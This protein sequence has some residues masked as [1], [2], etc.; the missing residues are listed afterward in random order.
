MWQQAIGDP[1][2]G[3]LRIQLAELGSVGDVVVHVV[4]DAEHSRPRGLRLVADG[5]QGP[6]VPVEGP[7]GADGTVS[8]RLPAPAAAAVRELRIEVEGRDVRTPIPGDPNPAAVLPIAI[9][10][11]DGAGLPV[12]QEAAEGT[13]TGSC[14]ELVE[15]D[16]RPVRVQAIGTNPM[17]A[18]GLHLVA[19]DGPLELAA[20]EHVIRS[21]DGRTTGLDV[22]RLVL[23]SAADGGAAEVGPRGSPRA[24]AGTTV[25]DVADHRDAVDARLTSD[26]RPFW[27][28]LGESDNAGWD[29][30]VDGADVSRPQIVDGYANGWLVTPRRAGELAVHLDWHPQRQVSI[31]IV[32]SLLA[33]LACLVLLWR[34]RRASVPPPQDAPALAFRDEGA[35]IAWGP[36]LLTALGL[37]VLAVL[38][39]SPAAGAVAGIG[40]VVAGRVR[41]APLAMAAAAALVI[42]LARVVERPAMAWLGL[43]LLL[44]A[45]VV[46]TMAERATRPEVS[47]SP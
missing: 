34:S 25:R 21:L 26:G 18:A 31:A 7:P 39:A 44:A 3:A 23:S 24:V 20:G 40:T 43:A 36:L 32:G 14:E 19:C 4:D 46:T 2:D 38:T 9:S 1:Q 29:L 22:D 10:E 41:W 15:V 30:R 5:K 47:R 42:P 13:V 11:V 17:T 16:G 35:L 6:I 33:V 27:L 45:A 12:A 8:V 28:V 37:G